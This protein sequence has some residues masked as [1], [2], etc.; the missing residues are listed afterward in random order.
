MKKIFTVNQFP[1]NEHGE[2]SL[3]D[4]TPEEYLAKL[5]SNIDEGELCIAKNA[6]EDGYYF[7]TATELSDAT[8]V[9]RYTVD[10]SKAD[11]ASIARKE[12]ELCDV[13]KAISARR[14]EKEEA[15]AAVKAVAE[16][17]SDKD[18]LR[19]A[20]VLNRAQRLGKMFELDAPDLVILNERC[21]L[22]EE[23]A[24]NAFATEYDVIAKEDFS[25]VFGI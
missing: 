4:I 9:Y 6:D 16:S 3:G 13:C 1:A 15:M 12:Q 21:C 7:E 2:Y 23:L 24:L 11:A 20:N 5:Y 18:G 10:V 8:E 22:A 17:V 19:F 25:K 14:M